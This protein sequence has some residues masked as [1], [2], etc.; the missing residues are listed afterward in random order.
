MGGCLGY[1][2][3]RYA[4]PLGMRVIRF[5]KCEAQFDKVSTKYSEFKPKIKIAK[6]NGETNWFDIEENELSQ[7][8]NILTG[9]GDK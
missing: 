4:E 1:G 2:I 3:G 8:K 5:F 7:I 6:P 9:G